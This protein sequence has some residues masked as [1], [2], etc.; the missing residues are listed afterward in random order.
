[1]TE[2][3]HALATSAAETMVVPNAPEQLQIRPTVSGAP[4][5]TALVVDWLLEPVVVDDELDLLLDEHAVAVAT[6][7]TA[8]TARK[9][10]DLVL[11]FSASPFD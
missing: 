3:A 5:A 7:A 1:M 11:T 6:I 2:L 4:V 8:P 9:T 10:L